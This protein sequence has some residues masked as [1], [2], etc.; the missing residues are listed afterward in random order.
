MALL[1]TRLLQQLSTNGTAPELNWSFIASATP[2]KQK[3][4]EGFSAQFTHAQS[5]QNKN[6]CLSTR[7]LLSDRTKAQP[8]QNCVA[9]VK[10]PTMALLPQIRQGNLLFSPRSLLM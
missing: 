5:H 3:T 10:A 2:N 7:F 6:E 4:I 9:D 8:D 1:K